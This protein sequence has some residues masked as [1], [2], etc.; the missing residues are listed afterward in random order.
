MLP[1]MSAAHSS[2]SSQMGSDPGGERRPSEGG[3]LGGG[4]TP[5]P[6]THTAG[7]EQVQ[8]AAAV[9]GHTEQRCLIPCQQLPS[10]LA[11]RHEGHV[12]DDNAVCLLHVVQPLKGDTHEVGWPSVPTLC[13]PCAALTC[14]EKAM[15]TATE[16]VT[17]PSP[18]N[19]PESL[20]GGE[21]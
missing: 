19:V 8:L 9:H 17:V 7:R 4:P 10:V 6:H 3:V 14:S 16:P 11:L 18:R 1:T 15:C 12:G 2:S 20:Q 21:Q 5:Q 13:P